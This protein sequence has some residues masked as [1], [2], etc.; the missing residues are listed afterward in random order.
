MYEGNPEQAAMVH[1]EGQLDNVQSFVSWIKDV[2]GMPLFQRQSFMVG[3]NS[4]S[5]RNY[6][7]LFN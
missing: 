6:L 4:I 5:L 1:S 7:F 3:G 2:G